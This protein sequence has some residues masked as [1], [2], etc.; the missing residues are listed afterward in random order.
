MSPVSLSPPG[1]PAGHS[2]LT[3]PVRHA[4]IGGDELGQ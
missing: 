3:I 1:Q 4:G 2:S